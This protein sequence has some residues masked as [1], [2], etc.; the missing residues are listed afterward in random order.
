MQELNFGLASSHRVVLCSP[1]IPAQT[2]QTLRE[3]HGMSENTAS[4]VLR[5]KWTVSL[6]S[7]SQHRSLDLDCAGAAEGLATVVAVMLCECK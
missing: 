6:T 2:L 3:L 7:G 1:G 4:K 5:A